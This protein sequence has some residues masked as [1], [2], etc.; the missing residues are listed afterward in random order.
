MMRYGLSEDFGFILTKKSGRQPANQSTARPPLR[1]IYTTQT[2]DSFAKPR[3][4]L[5]AGLAKESNDMKI[6]V[7]QGL[8]LS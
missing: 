1:T 4:E 3:L 8:N 6:V 7:I 5:S 2:E